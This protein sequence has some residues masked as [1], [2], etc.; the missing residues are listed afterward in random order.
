MTK[1]LEEER[2]EK[3]QRMKDQTNKLNKREK[4]KNEIIK[5][6]KKGTANDDLNQMI[7]D[8]VEKEIKERDVICRMIEQKKRE[9]K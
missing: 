9:R 8:S 2:N 7:Q 3:Q 6:V 1:K 5:E 4:K